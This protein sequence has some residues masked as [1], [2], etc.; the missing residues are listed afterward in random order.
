MNQADSPQQFGKLFV[1]SAA[2]GAGK[3]SLVR[4]LISNFD[5][6]TVSIS[7]TTRAARPGEIDGVHY[8]FVNEEQ[9]KQMQESRQFLESAYVFNHHYGTSKSWVEQTLS[10][11][12]DVM[13]ELDWQGMRSLKDS[14]YSVVT[15]FIL[16]PSLAELKS[17]LWQRGQDSKETIEY[18]LKCAQQEN[19]HYLEYDYLVINDKFELAYNDL[20]AIITAERLKLN[21]QQ[22]KYAEQ[23]EELCRE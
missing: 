7:H 21:I 15:I 4:R 11:G 3:T 9:F 19:S 17:R 22:N 18:R 1:V 12:Q 23:L 16:P 14:V 20:A 6:I 13:L 5:N 2:S 10:R 8:H